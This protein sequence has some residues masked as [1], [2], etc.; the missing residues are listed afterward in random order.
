MATG[1]DRFAACLVKNVAPQPVEIFFDGAPIR[2][3]VG[4]TRSLPYDIALHCVNRSVVRENPVT[5][6]RV[7]TLVIVQPGEEPE[8]LKPEEANPPERLDRSDM[9]PTQF[10]PEGDAIPA[11]SVK[12]VDI[13]KP[14]GLMRG[15]GA[16]GRPAIPAAVRES[17]DKGHDTLF[18]VV[19][20]HGLPGVENQ[21][22]P[23]EE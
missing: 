9:V 8:Q 14:V 18:D 21:T 4:E 6:E 16:G 10:T 11:G 7:S 3:E 15:R 1:L 2:W 22:K 23:N 12:Y 19:Q 13:K 17:L 5:L 20:E